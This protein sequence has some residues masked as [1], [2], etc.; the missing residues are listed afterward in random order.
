[1]TCLIAGCSEP[2][3]GIFCLIH[4]DEGGTCGVDDSWYTVVWPCNTIRALASAFATRDGYDT[5]WGPT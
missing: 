1:M 3:A 5:D 4:L 2:A